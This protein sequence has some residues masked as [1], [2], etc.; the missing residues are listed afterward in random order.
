M[1]N[2]DKDLK[3]CPFCNEKPKWA[4]KNELIVHKNNECFIANIE[5]TIEEWN[6]RATPQQ[7]SEKKALSVGEIVRFFMKET[8]MPGNFKSDSTAEHMITQIVKYTVE[9]SALPA[10]R[11]VRYPE[12]ITYYHSK[13]EYP[14][15]CVDAHNEAIDKFKK[16]NEESV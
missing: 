11:E 16:L 4:V 5:T 2:D 1:T 10:Q 12:K 13:K 14:Q 15:N 9:H 8:F 7:P 6:T 3:P